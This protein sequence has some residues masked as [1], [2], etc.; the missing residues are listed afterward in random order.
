M[1]RHNAE[2]LKKLHETDLGTN[3]ARLEREARHLGLE[4]T[5]AAI[6]RASAQAVCELSNKTQKMQERAA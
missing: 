5:A 4:G 3:L 1:R 6:G 2:R